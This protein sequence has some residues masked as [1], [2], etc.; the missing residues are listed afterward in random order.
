MHERRAAPALAGLHERLVALFEAI[1]ARA[2]RVLHFCWRVKSAGSWFSLK[3]NS[4]EI[5][6]VNDP[7]REK[8]QPSYG[9]IPFEGSFVEKSGK[10]FF[11]TF[12]LSG[13]IAQGIKDGVINF[14]ID[15]QPY[16]QGYVPVM[17]LT[18]YNRYGVLPGNNVNSGP[19]FVT[20]ANV[21]LVEKLAGEYR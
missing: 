20:K 13:E 21:G 17:V 5:R 19:G 12:D 10:I 11:G 6:R 16:L 15:Q 3:R 1:S 8:T 2:A 18:L 7:A 14:G 9:Q 4:R